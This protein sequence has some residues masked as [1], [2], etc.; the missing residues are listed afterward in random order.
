MTLAISLF[1]HG[2]AVRFNRG[3]SRGDN[4]DFKHMQG[5]D[6]NIYP[7]VSSQCFKRY[8]REALPTPPSPITRGKNTK[9]EEINQAFTDGN[10]IDYVDDDL[11]GYMIAG[12]EGENDDGQTEAGEELKIETPDDVDVAAI[13][14]SLF[15]VGD[16]NDPNALLKRLRD[17]ENSLSVY[18]MSQFSDESK[19]ELA[20]HNPDNPMPPD[21]ELIL[22]NEVNKLLQIELY[23][24]E[25]FKNKAKKAVKE[26]GDNPT[27]KNLTALNRQIVEKIYSKEIIR[28]DPKRDTTKRTAPIRMHALVAFSGVKVAKDFQTFSRDVPLTGKNSVVNPNSIGIYSGWLKTRILIEEHRIGKF[29]IG[30]NMDILNNQ[31]GQ[32]AR[33]Q[34]E[35][36]PYSR[37]AEKARFYAIEPEE[38]KKRFSLAVGALADIGNKQGPASGALHD[39]SLKPKAFIAAFMKCAD[40]PFDYI[41]VSKDGI[42]KIDVQRLQNAIRDWQGLFE[43]EMIYIGVPIEVGQEEI[44]TLRKAVEEL[45]FDGEKKFSAEITTSRQALLKLAED[46]NPKQPK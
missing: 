2:E 15:S 8:W 10:P 16:I 26:A 42:P 11:F 29:Y 34:E 27:G 44:D 31:L 39:G 40:S 5:S 20:N 25:E 35:L 43:R 6:G 23:K 28:K 41:W 37:T 30:K 38:R 12:A 19:T 21:L 18:L 17:S 33:A 24:Q 13:D 9:G 3:K 14:P 22:V 7:Y 1:V 45:P 32:N 46:I 36:N 4:Y